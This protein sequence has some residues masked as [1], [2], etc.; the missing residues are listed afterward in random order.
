MHA[1]K[2]VARAKFWQ[3]VEPALALVTFFQNRRET[4]IGEA[5]KVRGLEQL[6]VARSLVFL[7]TPAGE[8]PSLAAGQ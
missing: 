1:G 4:G 8:E 2:P 5:F 7:T 6:P 3:H